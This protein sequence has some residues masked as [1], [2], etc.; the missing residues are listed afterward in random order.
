MTPERWQE[1]KK[2]LA[3]VLEREPSER[4]AYLDRACAEPS[5]RQEVE[6]LIAAHE[7]GN[8]SFLEPSAARPQALKSGTKLGCYEIV[9]PIGSGGMGEVY[10]ARDTKLGRSV[11]IK[12]LPAAFARDAERMARF[13]REAKVLASLNHTNIAAIYG[14]EDSSTTHALVMELVDGPTL[15]D[16]IRQ[17]SIPVG[18]ALLI[19]KQITEA[20]E[21]AHEHGIVHRDLKPANVKLTRDDAVK[22]LDFGLAKAI[23]G[24]ASSTD[25]ADSPTISFMAT[26]AGILLGTAAYMSPEQAKAKPVDRRADIWAFGCVLY[27]MLTGRMAFG[28]ETVTDTLA[29]VIKEEPD[30]S[31]LPAATPIRVRVLLQRCLQKDPKQRLRDIGDA[32]ISLDEVLTGAREP[33]SAAAAPAS[34]LGRRTLIVGLAALLLVAA[35][36]SLVTWNLKPAPPSKPVSRFAI[37]LPPGQR[38]DIGNSIVISPDGT[39]L[40]YGAGPGNLA[41]QLYIRAMDTLDARPIPG[42]EGVGDPFFS[43]DGQWLG[44]SNDKKLM[45]VSLSGGAPVILSDVSG[46]TWGNSWGTESVIAFA[47]DGAIP[48]Q[49]IPDTG[50]NPQPLT[51]LEKTEQGQRWPE[52]LPGGKNLVFVSLLGGSANP[53]LVAQSLATGQ[54][55]DLQQTGTFP[56]YTPSGHLVYVQGTNLMAVPFDPQRLT[57]TGPAVPV[58]EGVLA[59]RPAGGISQTGFGYPQYSF[60]STGTLVYVPDSGRVPQLKLVWVDRKGAEQPVPAPAHNYVIPRISPDGK[61]VAVNIEEAESQIWLYDLGRDTLTRLTFGGAFNIDPLWTPD[62]RR[63]V[64]KGSGNRLFWQPAD[65][66]GAAEELTGSE[67]SRNNVPGSWTPDGQVLAFMEANLNTGSDIYTLSLNDRKPQ[68]FLR[69]PSTETAPRFSPDGRFI[70]Y[71][72]D[73]SSRLEIYVRPYPG[74]GGKWQISTEGGSEPVWNPKGRELF[75]RVGNKM[76]AVD[77]TTEGT[78]SAGKPKVLFEAPYV[79]TPRSFPDYDVTPDGQ[80][81]LML[82]PSEQAPPT[83]INVVLN[84][85]EELKQKVPPGNK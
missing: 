59:A 25:I 54:R 10:R 66:S 9:A 43:P 55:R 1:V 80:R 13:Q 20:L 2:H 73:E 60:S 15:A 65:G 17:R 64:F 26:Q 46:G 37:S 41:T 85:F 6:S 42:T 28:R 12:V 29:A 76:M 71:A 14:L 16:R 78:F 8:S 57:I 49:Q 23:E 83:Q 58:I 39:R 35:I 40:V 53:K 36:A 50:G 33:S 3:A 44:F 30:W 38:L 34:P 18:E 62:G 32:R 51:R 31:Q 67:L 4:S 63:I 7:Q 79:L 77:V 27:E 48:I 24:D 22:I 11:A 69:T 56:R 5:L 47:S 84:W 70:A 45:K 74:P 72:S 68:P 81:F 61:R 75:F 82:K 19:A 21:Y 52:F